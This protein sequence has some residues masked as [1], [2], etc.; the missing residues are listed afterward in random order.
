MDAGAI[1]VFTMLLGYLYN[2]IR[3]LKECYQSVFF[4]CDMTVFARD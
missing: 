3:I 4:D 2:A 1:Y